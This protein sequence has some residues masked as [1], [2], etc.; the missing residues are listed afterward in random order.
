MKKVIFAVATA[1][2]MSLAISSCSSN[3]GDQMIKD[4]EELVQKV[5]SAK[6]DPAKLMGLIEEFA[7]LGEKYKDIDENDFT[8][9][10][11]K[12]IEELGE[13]LDNLME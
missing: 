13:K 3:K 12:K 7:K 1:L 9:E 10:Q 8:P 6:G 5:E 4:M 11:K 2:V